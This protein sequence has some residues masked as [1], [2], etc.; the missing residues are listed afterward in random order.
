MK[1]F[2]ENKK[3]LDKEL[4]RFINLLNKLL[5]QYHLLLQ[6][7][8][9]SKD[10]LS[11]LGEIEHYLMGINAKIVEI[12]SKLEQDLFGQSL[13]I[14]YALKSKAIL[15]D[16]GARLKLESMR[17]AFAEA[18]KSGEVINYN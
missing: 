13:D 15:G 2:K 6:K 16:V 4:E 9:L 18:L 8:D 1:D 5:P 10:E 3:A 17:S 11:E 14:Y 12:K 7:N